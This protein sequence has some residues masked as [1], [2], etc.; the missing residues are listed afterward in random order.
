MK[1]IRAPSRTLAACAI[2]AFVGCSEWP[3]Y[4][5][6]IR[7]NL[8]ENREILEE[9]EAILDENGYGLI[10][11]MGSGSITIGY[12]VDGEI[13]Y[14]YI[15]DDKGW[16]EL[17]SKAKVIDISRNEDVFFFFISDTNQGDVYTFMQ[18]IHHPDADSEPAFPATAK[19][20]VANA[21]QSW[22]VNGGRTTSGFRMTSTTRRLTHWQMAR[23]LR[24]NTIRQAM[25]QSINAGA[26]DMPQL[27]MN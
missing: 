12:E 16:G 9:L 1:H 20:G 3:P 17:L 15:D 26:M 10:R 14:H 11:N 25:R 23:S 2:L 5:Q 19:L 21:S 13:E 4:E 24:T 27:A 7:D 6:D 22:M 18:Y 8:F